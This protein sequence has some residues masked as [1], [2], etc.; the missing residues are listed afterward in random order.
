MTGISFESDRTTTVFGDLVA[1]INDYF[2]RDKDPATR[3]LAGN[4]IDEG[5]LAVRR[6]GSTDDATFPP[7]FKRRFCAGDVLF[8]SRNPK[9]VVQPDFDGVTG[10][11]LFVLR[12]KDTT[13]L[14]QETVPYLLLTDHFADYVRRSRAGSVN[15]FLNWTPLAK[16][17]FALPPPEEQ[18][19]IA[20]AL[21]AA[22]SLRE[23][24]RSVRESVYRITV[25]LVEN[26]MGH[27]SE[28]ELVPTVELLREPPRNGLSP[29]TNSEGVGLRTV[30]ISAVR[31]GIFE[32]SGCIKHAKI[33]ADTA[34]PFFVRSGD[35]FVIRGNGN[36]QLCGKVGLSEHSYDGLFYPDLLIRLRF[37]TERMLPEFAVAQ[38][39]LPSVHRRLSARAKSSNG[40]WKVNGQDIRAHALFAPSIPEQ[41]AL[42][43]DLAGLRDGLRDA[44]TREQA[45]LGVKAT[46]LAGMD[47]PA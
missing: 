19:R 31:S 17:K 37:N 44:R 24:L 25:G 4:H 16:Y 8:H 41:R 42:L 14:L 10:E 5:D 36:R 39:N 23:T 3:Y 38:W 30:S 43:E 33:D 22:D 6:W 7:T 28:D 18:G 45:I 13:Q 34:R 21:A 12:S 47:G 15:K 35:V 11:K 20:S 46:I 9:K 1:N 32:P 29:S 26:V 27:V 2:D 40:I